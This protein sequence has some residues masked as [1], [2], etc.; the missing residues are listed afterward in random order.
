MG[1]LGIPVLMLSLLVGSPLCR[2]VFAQVFPGEKEA[3]YPPLTY[4]RSVGAKK[5][6][7][8]GLN[9]L[10]SVDVLEYSGWLVMPFEVP[11]TSTYS[12]GC[13]GARAACRAQAG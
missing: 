10:G 4:L 1:L 8:G 12:L 3:L 2:L 11:R 9:A 6:T 13:D 5:E 7:L